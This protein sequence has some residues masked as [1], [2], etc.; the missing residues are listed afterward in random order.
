MDLRS[1]NNEVVLDAVVNGGYSLEIENHKQAQWF[2]NKIVSDRSIPSVKVKYI[3]KAINDYYDGLY[4]SYDRMSAFMDD[5]DFW[6]RFDE[7]LD[8]QSDL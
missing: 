3:V 5:N 7:Y 8:L 1:E 4:T 2:L 6:D